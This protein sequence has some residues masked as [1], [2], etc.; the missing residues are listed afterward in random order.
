MIIEILRDYEALIVGDYMAMEENYSIPRR[1]F[2]GDEMEIEAYV[3]YDG[4]S[5][6]VLADGN[7]C[8]IPTAYFKV[9]RQSDLD[10]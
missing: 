3:D 9:T 10:F 8:R 2:V 4:L 1:F 7:E 5:R 6:I